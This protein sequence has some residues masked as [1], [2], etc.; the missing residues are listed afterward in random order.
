[1]SEI[2][3]LCDRLQDLNRDTGIL[4]SA[5]EFVRVGKQY[6]GEKDEMLVAD[7]LTVLEKQA[8][9]VSEF[10]NDTELLALR[11]KN[12]L[13][14]KSTPPGNKSHDYLDM[15]FYQIATIDESMVVLEEALQYAPFD[16]EEKGKTAS[17]LISAVL[18]I[19]RI[20]IPEAERLLKELCNQRA[21]CSNE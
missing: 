4:H 2:K 19:Q 7:M 6:M 15:I 11:I 20:A 10:T 3:T 13:T 1:M 8:K 17:K 12:N 21:G 18:H 9:C 5:V 16:G 14:S